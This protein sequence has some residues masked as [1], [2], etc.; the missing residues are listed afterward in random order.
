MMQKI[1][2]L[3]LIGLIFASCKEDSPDL[4]IKNAGILVKNLN[5][6]NEATITN[7]YKFFA[8]TGTESDTYIIQNIDS[9]PVGTNVTRLKAQFTIRNDKVQV[10]VNGVLQV[11]G[12]TENDFTSPVIYQANIENGEIQTI[13]VFVNVA[14]TKHEPDKFILLNGYLNEVNCQKIATTFG[15]QS[16]KNIAVGIG[17]IVSYLQG[18]PT[19]MLSTLNN[20]LGLSSKYSLPIIVQLDGEQW[21]DYRS[22]LWNWWSPGATGY[23]PAN[24]DNVEW[25]DWTSDAAI[26][27]GWRNWGSQI[28]VKPMPNLMSP[29]YRT[30]C[31]TEMTKMVDAVKTWWD[32]LP[33]EKKYLFVGIKV[34]WES[35]IGVNNWYYPNGNDYLTKPASND[36]KTGLTNALPSRGVQTI[37]YAAVR[38][39]GIASSGILTDAM[40]AEV[41]RRHLEDLSKSVKEQGIPR[42]RIFTHCGG[43]VNGEALFNS[44]INE[45]SCPGWSFYSHS[46]DPTKDTDVM[47]ALKKNTAPYWAA[48]EWL[49]Q[50]NKSK[51]EWVSAFR[52]TLGEHTRYVCVYNW[53]SI[54]TNPNAI[55]A[56]LEMNR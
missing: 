52:M 35:A 17:V 56:I 27:I 2:I 18:T 24:K 55:D 11:S 36:P 42:E 34:G 14:K 19:N 13:R 38:T 45:Y 49:L 41:V 21:W 25:Y 48:A 6:D 32:A 30:A 1:F 51:E 20:Y 5:F 4:P 9:L 40:Q 44:A 46:S 37:G 29:A 26:K 23:N 10:K 43:W 22:D 16:N 31:H 53:N 12:V 28:R 39:A 8:S 54:E 33:E 47:A 15:K 50:G 3:I 7:A